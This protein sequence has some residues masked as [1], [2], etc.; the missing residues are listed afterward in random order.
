MG[1]G[2]HLILTLV[3]V[4]G[5]VGFAIYTLVKHFRQERINDASP[6]EMIRAKV[7]TNSFVFLRLP[8]DKRMRLIFETDSGEKTF[9]PGRNHYCSLKL[10]TL[11]SGDIG[12]LSYQGTR[13]IR[14]DKYQS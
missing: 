8:T 14:F 7:K 11:R 1:S 9:R 6:I 13:I 12:M 4:F 10:H 3:V 2:L 5:I